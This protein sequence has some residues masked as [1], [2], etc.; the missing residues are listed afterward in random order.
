M[1]RFRLFLTSVL[2]CMLMTISSLAG[3]WKSDAV[4]WWYECDD[5]SY[6]VNS[7][8]WIDGNF[9]GIAE[10]YYFDSNG[11]CLMN[12]VTPDGCF[13]DANGAWIVDG[14]VQTKNVLELITPQ[15]TIVEEITPQAL[16]EAADVSNESTEFYGIS[17]IAYDGYTIIANT[18]TKKYHV[19][20]CK[21]VDQMKEA[22]KGYCS[23]EA[24]LLSNFY[25]PCK[26]CH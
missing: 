14:T 15:P 1:K 24:Y 5:G 16:V 19:P 13:V 11:Y 18:N 10:C 26:N 9:D 23:D 12:S 8:N 21:S 20:S 22:N 3:S 7:W 2:L 6:Y 17:A 4:G 25:Q